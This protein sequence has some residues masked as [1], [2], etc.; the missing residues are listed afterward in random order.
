MTE[1]GDWNRDTVSHSSS[2]SEDD[3]QHIYPQ[4]NADLSMPG[5]VK[6]MIDVLVTGFGPF[7]DHNVNASWEAVKELEKIGV[8]H[9]IN[10]VTVEVPVVYEAVKELVPTLWLEYKPQLVVHVG[11]S[12][13][14]EEVT[15]ESCAN[16]SGY[17]RPDVCGKTAPSEC[18]K[19]NG[20]ECIASGLDVAKICQDVNE[21]NCLAMAL[22]SHDAG[23]YLCEFTFYASLCR[24][25]KRVIF[26]HVPPLGEP[27]TARELG[28]AL[29]S[30]II[31]MLK[32]LNLYHPLSLSQEQQAA[33]DHVNKT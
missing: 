21:S 5:S 33:I 13:I 23:R 4:M 26:V 19:K 17:Y 32:Q 28:H 24:D 10:L 8:A 31:S 6:P 15:I 9:N 27:Y 22:T 2:D 16:N 11:V 7:G 18:F 25:R 3:D 12:G 30:V 1:T 20:E 14:A 29:R